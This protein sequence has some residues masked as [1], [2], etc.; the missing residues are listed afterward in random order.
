MPPIH[1]HWPRFAIPAGILTW[2]FEAEAAR[3]FKNGLLRRKRPAPRR[4]QRS[5]LLCSAHAL[6]PTLFF[7]FFSS[8]R[9]PV[10]GTHGVDRLIYTA[11][12]TV[13]LGDRVW[14]VVRFGHA[15]RCGKQ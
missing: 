6:P 9:I 14:C 12:L 3:L 2:G 7:F 8:L 10:S 1:P 15:S 11:H 4:V 13:C 5:C